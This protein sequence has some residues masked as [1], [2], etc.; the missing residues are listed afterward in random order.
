MS[1]TESLEVCSIER[2]TKIHSDISTLNQN[3]KDLISKFKT[4]YETVGLFIDE[5]YNLYKTK[6][7]ELELRTLKNKYGVDL[8]K[9]DEESER[10]KKR[11]LKRQ[12]KL[13]VTNDD[14]NR[15]LR[16]KKEVEDLLDKKEEQLKLD[17]QKKFQDDIIKK[18]E[19]L[20]KELEDK[21]KNLNIQM[22]K[23]VKPE[24]TE[25][26]K[27]ETMKMKKEDVTKLV[28]DKLAQVLKL[29]VNKSKK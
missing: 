23:M 21:I 10:K 17:E 5:K 15:I 1:L 2:I 18:N 8:D 4:Q 6:L 27:D 14:E 12:L 22:E 3:V 11:K 16:Q 19:A 13:K 25:Q 26:T 20:K 28:N 9:H 29:I 7:K 24:E